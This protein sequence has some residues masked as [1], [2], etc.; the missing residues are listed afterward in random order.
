[1]SLDIGFS[2]AWADD[3]Y[4]FRL[5]V[6]QLDELQDITGIGAE[7]LYYRLTTPVQGER[8][9]KTRW[10]R[11]TIRL[12]LIGGGTEPAKAEKLCKMYVDDNPTLPNLRFAISALGGALMG[13]RKAADGKKKKRTPNVTTTTEPTAE[14]TPPST[15]ASAESA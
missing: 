15:E 14:T 12:S 2:D 3:T 13:I 10:M 6:K 4:H 8:N 7:L 9:W 1:M 5:G 11:E